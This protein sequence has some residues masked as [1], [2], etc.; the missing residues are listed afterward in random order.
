MALKDENLAVV[1]AVPIT[2][3]HIFVSANNKAV[4]L[5]TVDIPVQN[6]VTAGV[7]IIDARDSNTTIEIM[8]GWI[9]LLNMKNYLKR[10]RV[11]MKF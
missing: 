4:L 6:R 7:R 3:E 2:Q 8:W 10:L 9:W 11:Q 5:E 1:Y